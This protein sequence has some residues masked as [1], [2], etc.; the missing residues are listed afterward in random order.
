MADIFEKYQET[1][2]EKI[3][4]EIK[5][6]TK[7]LKTESIKK[8]LE[9]VH[10]DYEKAKVE[11]GDT[12]G[13]AAAHSMGEPGTQMSMR[14]FHYAGIAE[15]SLSTGLPRIIELV[16]VRKTPE[17]PAMWIYTEFPKD[18]Q[19]T[20]EL[21]AKLE[22]VTAEQIADIVEDFANKKIE[23]IIHEDKIKGITTIEDTLK[24]IEK[25]IRKKANKIEANMAIFEPKTVSLRALRKYTNKIKE[26][27]IYGIPGI[28]K[29]AVVEKN[30]EYVIQ[31]EGTNL[32]PV[33][34]FQGVDHKRTIS[35]NPKEVE[36]VLG[37]EAARSVLLNE[38]KMV[39][40]TQNFK[41]NIRH[42]MLLADLMTQDGTIKAIGRTGISGE[43][44]SVFARAAFEETRNHI[45]NAA[46][47]GTKDKLQGVTEN[48]IVGQPIPVGTGTVKLKMT[49]NKK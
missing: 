40:D 2:P 21:A 32:K 19:K 48:I 24:A 12:V 14:T 34:E 26:T 45:L 28:K 18:K 35:N 16:D 17:T 31:T 23:I 20:I 13:I 10:Q 4:T 33:L 36:E 9:Q 37:I 42:L 7:S 49:H 15:L 38:L 29:A 27:K 5:G 47:K 25:S 22:E 8:I 11:I 43:K 46:I 39:L 30:N 41:V 44:E 6:A 3:L 1:L